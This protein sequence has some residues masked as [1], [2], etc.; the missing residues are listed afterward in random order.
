M[1]GRQLH[2]R[3][4]LA[5][6]CVTEVGVA[7]PV[8]AAN[9]KVK[10]GLLYSLG[11]YVCNYDWD[12]RG[13]TFIMLVKGAGNHLRAVPAFRYTPTSTSFRIPYPIDKRIR[14]ANPFKMF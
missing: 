11:R 3:A 12:W 9:M 14:C 1:H 13:A 7:S 2:A 5:H 8:Q 6:V 10:L 4:A